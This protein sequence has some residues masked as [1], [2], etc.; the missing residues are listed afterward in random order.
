MTTFA[1]VQHAA[2]MYSLD[3]AMNL[4]ELDAWL[5]R[6]RAV[7]GERE[8]AFVCELKID[9]SSL[10]LTY[11]DAAAGARRDPRVTGE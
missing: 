6:V 9:G 5:G 11:E 10:A 4:D 2:R 3:N 1:P 8:C 7:V